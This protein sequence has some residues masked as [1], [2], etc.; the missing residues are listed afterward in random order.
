MPRRTAVGPPQ[1][2]TYLSTLTALIECPADVDWP[3]CRVQHTAPGLQHAAGGPLVPQD[4]SAPSGAQPQGGGRSAPKTR[5]SDAL[6][7]AVRSCPPAAQREALAALRA[8]CDRSVTSLHGKWPAV[9]SCIAHLAHAAY[10]V[11]AELSASARPES[12]RQ[13]LSGDGS[14]ASVH[15]AVAAQAVRLAGSYI[16]SLHAAASKASC[17]G[18][19]SP[20]AWGSQPVQDAASGVDAETRFTEALAVAE[21]CVSA[22]CEYAQADSPTLR[23]AALAAC[24]AVPR[25]LWDALPVATSAAAMQRASHCATTDAVSAVRASAVQALA[26]TLSV[27]ALVRLPDQ[28]AAAVS[29]M[30]RACS[31][32]A[33]SVRVESAAA[34]AECCALVRSA[35]RGDAD[36]NISEGAHVARDSGVAQRTSRSAADSNGDNSEAGS[37]G[38]R[39]DTVALASSLLPAAVW[40]EL[41]AAALTA[42]TG[43]EK[44]RSQGVRAV[45]GLA[46][47][48]PLHTTPLRSVLPCRTDAPAGQQHCDTEGWRDW[49]RAGIAAVA[50]ALGTGSAKTAWNAAVAAGSIW[51]C[52]EARSGVADPD[53]LQR[54]L[55][56]VRQALRASASFKVRIHAAQALLATGATRECVGARGVASCLHDVACAFMALEAP[57]HCAAHSGVATGG[58]GDAAG[59]AAANFRYREALRHALVAALLCFSHALTGEDAAAL[60]AEQAPDVVAALR[61]AVLHDVGAHSAERYAQVRGAAVRTFAA[62]CASAHHARGFGHDLYRPNR[63]ANAGGRRHSGAAGGCARGKP[64][65]S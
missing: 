57:G 21:Q 62:A 51:G 45:G 29:A 10:A 64:C 39:H 12:R 11:S 31:H 15:E 30:S 28:A 49:L 54:L 17:N 32:A 37:I 34:V 48:L 1:A 33:A 19:S 53:A 60:R 22:L 46:A 58:P 13:S 44:A 42:A 52:A 59:D 23:T 16:R 43:S 3:S 40:V 5:L 2:A 25:Q 41:R 9:Q 55:P 24:A 47:V 6:F 8:L 61:L 7:A 50:N 35:V 4:V 65:E 36:A 14:S 20:G 27:A 38:Q 26:A 18:R 63:P 56:P